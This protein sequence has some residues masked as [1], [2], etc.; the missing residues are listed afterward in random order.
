MKTMWIKRNQTVIRKTAKAKNPVTTNQNEVL[1]LVTK[2]GGVHIAQSK[3]PELH[4]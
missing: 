1:V 3:A 2:E 4:I